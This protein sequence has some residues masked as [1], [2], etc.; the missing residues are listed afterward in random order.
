MMY[1]ASSRTGRQFQR[2]NNN[3]CRLVV[4]CI[5]YRFRKTNQSHGPGHREELEVLLIS[6]QKG[7]TLLFPKVSSSL[8][9]QQPCVYAFI[10]LA[11]LLVF[12]YLLYFLSC[13]LN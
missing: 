10:F 7:Q 3:G 8:T 11:L 5:P 2:Y 6:S 13:L 4:G 12:E 1:L 9:Y